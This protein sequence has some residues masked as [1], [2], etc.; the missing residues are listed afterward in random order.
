M[1]ILR[2][3]FEMPC[4]VDQTTSFACNALSL[5]YFI[6]LYLKKLPYSIWIPLITYNDSTYNDMTLL[7]TD[8]TYQ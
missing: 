6:G 1:F 2:K 7:T 8:F 3:S 5:K 4:M